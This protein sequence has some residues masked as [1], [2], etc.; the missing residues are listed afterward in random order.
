MLILSYEENRRRKGI[1]TCAGPSFV[2]ATTDRLISSA[3][4]VN[5][6]EVKVHVQ[7]RYSSAVLFLS[8]G[9]S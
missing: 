9:N 8:L 7:L 3:Q 2:R 1:G 4:S 5:G 6:E